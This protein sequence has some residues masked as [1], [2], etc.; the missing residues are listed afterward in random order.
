MSC[1]PGSRSGSQTNVSFVAGIGIVKR[2]LK[3]AS[4][5]LRTSSVVGATLR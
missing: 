1:P 4:N 5:Y 3:A 2:T